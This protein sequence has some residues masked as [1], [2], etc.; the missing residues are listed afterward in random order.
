MYFSTLSAADSC[1][2]TTRSLSRWRWV[3][4]GGGGREGWIAGDYSTPLGN[5]CMENLR[6][7]SIYMEYLQSI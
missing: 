7:S 4:C 6:L 2:T 1:R 3:V 5:T